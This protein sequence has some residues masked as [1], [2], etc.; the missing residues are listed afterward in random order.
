[1]LISLS[2]AVLV[3]LP[4]IIPYFFVSIEERGG[5]VPF[6]L[7]PSLLIFA[8]F[9]NYL[10]EL[11]FRGFL[12]T[13]LMQ[14]GMSKTRRI[15]LSGLFF[16][17]GH[18]FLA[19]TVTDLGALILIFTL[20]EGIICAAIYEKYGLMSAT[21]THGMAIFLLASGVVI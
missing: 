8:L 21:L 20:W 12:Q 17:M 4:F 1:M 2:A 11:L 7:L 10:E 14:Q 13:H 15:L 19:A 9:G 5:P 18:L 3:L 6:S 16:S